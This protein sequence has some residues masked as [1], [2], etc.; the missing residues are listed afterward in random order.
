VTREQVLVEPR[1]ARVLKHRPKTRVP[2]SILLRRAIQLW[3][4]V[5]V[6]PA[7]ALMRS[8]TDAVGPV[9]SNAMF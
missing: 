8:V 1:T 9:D 7:G 2:V 6:A 4:F 5:P 3:Y